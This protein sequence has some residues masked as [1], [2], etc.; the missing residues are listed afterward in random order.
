MS[1]WACEAVDPESEHDVLSYMSRH[2]I[3]TVRRGAD[4]R[5]VTTCD[6]E[7]EE[8]MGPLHPMCS[9]HLLSDLHRVLRNP[10]WYMV[11]LGSHG[12]VKTCLPSDSRTASISSSEWV[13]EEE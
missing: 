4:V 10:L 5:D 8:V 9:A 7:D 1:V 6:W 3:G 2:A 11:L 13:T 12:L